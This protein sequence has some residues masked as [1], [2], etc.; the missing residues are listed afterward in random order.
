MYDNNKVTNKFQ[1]II[2]VNGTSQCSVQKT[3]GNNNYSHTFNLINQEFV[4]IYDWL[5]ANKISLSID[6][7]YVND[8]PISSESIALSTK[9]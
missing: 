3:F 1:A 5:L 4:F 8:A 7:N 6:K 2:Y 9:T